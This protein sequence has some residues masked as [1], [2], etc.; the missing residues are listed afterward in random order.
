MPLSPKVA[1]EESKKRHFWQKDHTVRKPET[2]SF[3]RKRLP[4]WSVRDG[5]YFVTIR[6]KDTIP[7]DAAMKIREKVLELEKQVESFK[8]W[9]GYKLVSEIKSAPDLYGQ[10]K[11]ASLSEAGRKRGSFGKIDFSNADYA[12]RRSETIPFAG[13]A[14]EKDASSFKGIS[15][16]SSG[17]SKRSRQ[18]ALL[19]LPRIT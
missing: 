13:I 15:P 18:S 19:N 7:R 4:H 3:H 2:I 12:C 8:K 17:R 6:Q 11:Y 10:N 1:Q 5:L 14:S 16:V 9:T